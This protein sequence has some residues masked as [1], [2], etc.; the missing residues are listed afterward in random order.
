MTIPVIHK[1][2]SSHSLSLSPVLSPSLLFSMTSQ[3]FV[4]GI[5]AA[6]TIGIQCLG[7]SAAYALRTEVFYDVSTTISVFLDLRSGI[8]IEMKHVSFVHWSVC[9]K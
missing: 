2:S 3:G 7:F 6:I 9:T 1:V 4:Y 8:Q 5:A